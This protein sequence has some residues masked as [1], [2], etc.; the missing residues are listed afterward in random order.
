M[1]TNL[2]ATASVLLWFSFSFFVEL[3]IWYCRLR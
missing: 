1:D 3:F 2:S